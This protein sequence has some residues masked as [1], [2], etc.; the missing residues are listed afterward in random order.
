MI[1]PIDD[2]NLEYRIADGYAR[3]AWSVIEQTVDDIHLLRRFGVIVNGKCALNHANWPSRRCTSR[4]NT[5]YNNY[6]DH[7]NQ[8][9]LLIDWVYSRDL[10]DWLEMLGAGY[11]QDHIIS[12]LEGK[13]PFTDFRRV[14]NNWQNY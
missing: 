8:V 12:L 7:P 2:F 10:G 9:Q 1:A 6:Y 14:Y 13:I 3:L 5:R 11:M 4:S